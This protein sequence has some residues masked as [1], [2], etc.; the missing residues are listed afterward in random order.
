M[1]L[2]ERK[3][4]HGAGKEGKITTISVKKTDVDAYT[5]CIDRYSLKTVDLPK[6]QIR[7]NVG[8]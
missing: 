4:G 6:D 1:V 3:R 8:K 7:D 2:I 5:V